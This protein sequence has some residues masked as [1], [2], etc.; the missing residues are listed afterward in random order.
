MS[1]LRA[2]IAGAGF[3]PT[4]KIGLPAQRQNRVLSFICADIC[5]SRSGLG[6]SGAAQLGY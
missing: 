4:T 3:E 6:A 5:M 2:L 1:P